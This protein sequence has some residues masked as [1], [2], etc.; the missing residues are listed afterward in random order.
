MPRIGLPRLFAGEPHHLHVYRDWVA[1]ELPV[2]GRMLN[3]GCGD[4][5]EFAEFRSK[6]REVWG[7]DLVTHPQLTN[8]GWF[9]PTRSGGT[10]PFADGS[11][12]V[13]VCTWVLEHVARPIRFLREVERVLRPGGSFIAHTINSRHYVTWIRR[14]FDLFPHSWTARVV[15]SLYGR[16]PHDTFPTVYALNSP[17]QIAAAARRADLRLVRTR[18]FAD[19]GY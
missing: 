3:L 6:E 10:L 17:A 19:Q 1:S 8:S 13:V 15:R 11:F 2:S 9:R 18:C 7:S 14:A 4:N 16:E 12:D 5:S